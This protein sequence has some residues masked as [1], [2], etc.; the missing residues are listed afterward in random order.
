[1]NAP[2][3]DYISQGIA[4]KYHPPNGLDNEYYYFENH[5]K[6][7]I[8]DDIILNPN[9]KGILVLHQKEIYNQSDVLKFPTADGYRDWENPFWVPVPWA[10]G[11]EYPAQR[12]IG[13]NIN[14][15]N[16]RDKLPDTH[17]GYGW[18]WVLAYEDDSYEWGNFL[19]T[20]Y[21]FE[22]AYNTRHNNVFS[23]L[24]NPNTNTWNNQSTSFTMEVVNQNGSVLNVEYYLTNPYEGKPA[25][26]RDLKQVATYGQSARLTWDANT[27]PDLRRYRIYRKADMYPTWQLRAYVTGTTW[28][29]PEVIIGPPMTTWYWKIKAEDWSGK[30]S[31]YSY[32]VNAI[33]LIKPVVPNQEDT[34]KIPESFNL[35]QNYPNHLIRKQ[36][37]LLI[38]QLRVP[39]Y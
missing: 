31:L 6:V 39:L 34:N 21:P 1:M 29:D 18:F 37:F 17:G 25:V 28:T 27:E 7:S 32:E 4:Y 35:S 16:H 22:A 33:G 26:P 8:Y 11:D 15:Y 20:Q 30:K 13:W 5:Q 14:G 36:R 23:P 12:P 19:R 10:L 2:L 3:P 9:D 24:S 38:Y